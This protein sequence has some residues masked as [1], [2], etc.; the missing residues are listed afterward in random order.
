VITVGSS[1]GPCAKGATIAAVL[2]VTES[3]LPA[4][5][6][7]SLTTIPGDAKF[8]GILIPL[9]NPNY[10]EIFIKKVTFIGETVREHSPIWIM[11]F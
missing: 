7:T 3:T 2:S 10:L 5:K 6:S 4:V 1:T 8:S 9:A 11:P